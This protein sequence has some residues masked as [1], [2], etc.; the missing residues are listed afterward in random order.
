MRG[1]AEVEAIHRDVDGTILSHERAVGPVTY[2]IGPDGQPT[3]IRK[4]G[5]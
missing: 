3:D 2:I 1:I 4:E 5:A